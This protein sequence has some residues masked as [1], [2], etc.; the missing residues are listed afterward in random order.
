MHRAPHRCWRAWQGSLLLA[1]HLATTAAV[2][3]SYA[4]V[5]PQAELHRSKELAEV[6]EPY[7]GMYRAKQRQSRE[8][9]A[10]TSP[11]GPQT[12]YID[13]QIA[14][15]SRLQ[16]EL[17]RLREALE[18]A[19]LGFERADLAWQA[20]RQNP[21]LRETPPGREAGAVAL[22]DRAAA[23]ARLQAVCRCLLVDLP[24]RARAAQLPPAWLQ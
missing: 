15:R 1:L 4:W 22:E 11:A 24:A 18:A 10:A 2:P 19:L 3:A 17:A 14:A 9:A 8:P 12:P 23:F 21:L 20:S 5:D 7:A 13:A 16:Q 6:P